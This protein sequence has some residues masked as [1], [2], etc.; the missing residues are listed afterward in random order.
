MSLFPPV[1][2]SSDL[3]KSG[4]IAGFGF[5][6]LLALRPRNAVSVHL[7]LPLG[8]CTLS[9]APVVHPAAP[10]PPRESISHCHPYV[11]GEA[12]FSWADLLVTTGLGSAG[13]VL[14]HVGLLLLPLPVVE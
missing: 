4:L 13:M 2:V 1:S 11:C 5:G 12:G 7:S 10:K 6:K 14:L 9:L 8:G 3:L